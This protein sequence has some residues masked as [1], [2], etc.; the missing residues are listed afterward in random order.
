MSVDIHLCREDEIVLVMRFLHEHWAADHV[1]SWHRPLLDF[2]HRDAGGYNFVVARRLDGGDVL[3]VL[4]FIPTCLYDPQ[5]AD[6][7]M[8]WLALWKVRA[9]AGVAGL[10]LLL[11]HYLDANVPHAAIA[12]A[13]I[14]NP[15]HLAMY[16]ALGYAVGDY[17][18]HY[19][20]NWRIE[21]PFLGTFGP[22]PAP[23]AAVT[24]DATLEPLTTDTLL[25]ATRDLAL[26]ERAVQW[27]AKT[28]RYFLA[29][30]LGHPVYQYNVYLVRRAQRPVG[31]LA[32]RIA[33]HAGHRALRLV[34]YLGGEAA[35]GELGPALD[36][37][38]E[39]TGS[40]YADLWSLGLSD[41]TLA[42]AGFRLVDAAGPVIV[43]N[44]FE[45]FAPK[46]EVLRCAWKGP[47]G[48]S[49]VFFRADG[50]QD[51]PNQIPREGTA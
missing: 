10:G 38:L 18:Q 21:R 36:A 16:R 7:N 35:L 23:C 43:P 6:R 48:Q 11:L 25:A 33:T 27:P 37:V 14:G 46:N 29:R 44:F 34:D 17:R 9:D 47:A 12:V 15:A 28:P 2:Q 4:G 51:R 20:R 13:G 41:G 8:L 24:G 45:P 42:R 5:L 49:F 30:F 40:E 50:D 22:E 39:R 3:G 19:L 26:A 32:A 31:L 1:L